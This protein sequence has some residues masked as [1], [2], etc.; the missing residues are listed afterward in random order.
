MVAG[1]VEGMQRAGVRGYFIINRYCL[2]Q[3]ALNIQVALK[4][5]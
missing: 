3:Q 5:A 4:P 2:C 1:N